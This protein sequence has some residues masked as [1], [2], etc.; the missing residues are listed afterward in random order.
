MEQIPLK[1]RW[2]YFLLDHCLLVHLT[3][4][5]RNAPLK[6][7]SRRVNI[8]DESSTK[9]KRSI[10]D[11]SSNAP[12]MAPVEEPT[13]P[14][15]YKKSSIQNYFTTLQTKPSIA[16]DASTQVSS[17]VQGRSSTP[18][19]SPPP[20]ANC[21]DEHGVGVLKVRRRLNARPHL[22]PIENPPTTKTQGRSS[23][24]EEKDDCSF[25]ENSA[26]TGPSRPAKR[27]R[28]RTVQQVRLDLNVSAFVECKICK[29]QY[30]KTEKGDRNAHDKFHQEYINGKESK[31]NSTTI[32]LYSET[33]H[34]KRK[35]RNGTA[36]EAEQHKI[37]MIDRGSSTELRSQAEAALEL[38]YQDMDGVNIGQAEL[39]S[40]MLNPH[41]IEDEYKIPR[42]RLY[43]YYVNKEIA[44]ILLAE[45]I[46]EGSEYINA[47]VSYTKHKAH[48]GLERIWVKEKWRGQRIA[49]KL[50]DVARDSFI[51]G[52]VLARK[53]V[54]FS[55]PTEVGSIFAKN[56]SQGVFTGFDFLVAL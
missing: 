26:K 18:P 41:D 22:A 52:L 8:R 29:M 55:A 30:N 1:R 5:L 35:D 21:E 32:A 25:T 11:M 2:V 38:S 45:R 10:D 51:Q 40:E 12:V 23:T 13:L 56:Y 15:L 37:C 14:K 46:G 17:D 48:L 4:P 20:I 44:A 49:T 7:Y 6:T 33:I 53:D 16:S 28:P 47:R 54:A 43:I 9:R 50:V 31:D 34:A 27:I 36:Y 3:L 19:S 39:W 24:I 42:F